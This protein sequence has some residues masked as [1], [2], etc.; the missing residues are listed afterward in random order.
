MSQFTI[1]VVEDE[2]AIRSM[3]VMVLQQ[4]DFNVLEAGDVTE[5]QAMLD[6]TV[7]DLILLDWML[8]RITGDEWT[9][10]LKSNDSYRDLPI[11]LVTAKGEEADKIRGLDIGADDYVTKP[12]SPKELISRIKA[13]LRRSGK[14]HDLTQIKFQDIVMDIERHRVN[15]SDKEVDISPTEFKLLSFFL[16]HPDKVYNRTQ[17]LDQVWGRNVYIEERTVDVHIRRLR[18]I[19]AK[20]QREDWLQT[21][22]GFGYRFSIK[23][24]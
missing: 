16:T 8:P 7:P 3:L 19:L 12:F 23:N 14:I 20:Y 9:R 24:S 10:R 13:V 2:P 5:A 6:E 18:K 11:I 21:V 22:R 4:Y 1:L 15:I 17:L